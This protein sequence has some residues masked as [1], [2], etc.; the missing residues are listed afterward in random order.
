VTCHP[1]TE[2][3]EVHVVFSDVRVLRDSGPCIVRKSGFLYGAW[4]ESGIDSVIVTPWILDR[5]PCA[6]RSR[7]FDLPYGLFFTTQGDESRSV[8]VFRILPTQIQ[9]GIVDLAPVLP[10]GSHCEQPGRSARVKLRNPVGI[11][12]NMFAD[13][14][15]G[16]GNAPWMAISTICAG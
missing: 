10:T 6:I 3:K 13:N 7:P 15:R 11:V 16:S 1:Y 8:V 14:A 9:I 12:E 5:C 2:F 4:S